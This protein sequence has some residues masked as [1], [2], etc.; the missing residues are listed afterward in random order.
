MGDKY[1]DGVGRV[2]SWG[3]DR[4]EWDAE[5]I[6]AGACYQNLVPLWIS[7]Q[8]QLHQQLPYWSH[9]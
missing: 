8:S 1:V 6:Q 3:S 9:N 2:H 4:S 7:V 5:G